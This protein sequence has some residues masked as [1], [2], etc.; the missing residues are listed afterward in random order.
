MRKGTYS[1]F[2]ALTALMLVVAITVFS[3]SMPQA[4]KTAVFKDSI[5]ETKK[6]AQNAVLLL[7]KV[8]NDSIADSVFANACTESTGLVRQ[9]IRD[10]FTATA[11]EF[12][13]RCSITINSITENSTIVPGEIV[14]FTDFT[15]ACTQSILSDFSV[16]YTE[17]KVFQRH[18]TETKTGTNCSVMVLDGTARELSK[19]A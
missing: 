19:T 2:I 5:V 14:Y 11:A 7:D 10:Y 13:P 15:V 9:R 8:I 6:V 4:Q 18:A 3:G 17:N 16:T 12:Q 1:S